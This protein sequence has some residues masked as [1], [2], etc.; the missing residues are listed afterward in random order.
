MGDTLISSMGVSK[1]FL[2]LYSI[3]VMSLTSPPVRSLD[4]IS[5]SQD[6]DVELGMERAL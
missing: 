4:L 6:K 1:G 2:C 3:T 5:S